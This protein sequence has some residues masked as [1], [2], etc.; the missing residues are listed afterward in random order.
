MKQV[1]IAMLEPG[2]VLAEP[3]LN[4][5]GIVMLGPGTALTEVH[6]NR[7]KKLG[8]KDACIVNKEPQEKRP[9]AKAEL[10]SAPA[11][12][13]SHTPVPVQEIR[14]KWEKRREMR[15]ALIRLADA[16]LG[17]GRPSSPQMEEPFRR[18]FR[19]TL[20]EITRHD[21][22][23]DGLLRLERADPYLL[24]HS[25]H[26]TA[27]AAILGLANG[28]AGAEMLELC[29]GSLLFDIGMTELPAHTFSSTG[30][31][32]GAERAA[33]RL[34]PEAGHRIISRMEGVSPRSALCALQHHERFNGTGYPSR[35][36]HGEIDEYAE[37]VAIA[38]TYHAL[39]SRRNYRLAYTPGEAVEYLL[40]A[41][42]RYF[43]LDLI[44]TYLK[45][46]SIYPLSSVVRLSSG[47]L[48]VVTSLETSLVHR[49][50]VKIIRE[51]DG[52]LVSAPYEV[53]LMRKT[54]LVI[55]G[56]VEETAG[57]TI[58]A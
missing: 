13:G 41:G 24:E 5:R 46:I 31:L 29:V 30:S 4:Q 42:D 16:E 14:D 38:D 28:Y 11:A 44:Q 32:T 1:H 10:Q 47:Q 34:H 22:V 3:I 27:Y 49:P 19:N 18:M 54:D 6:I 45:H 15:Q 55:S 12:E 37:I 17:I 56:L 9:T 26:V 48:G 35:L 50:V 25:F 53:D 36:K 57:E 8:I 43:S 7:L 2:D 52:S 21:G 23:V 58:K 33:V 51:A 20:Y 40:A 39:I